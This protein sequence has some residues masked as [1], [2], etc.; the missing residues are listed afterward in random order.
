MEFYIIDDVDKPNEKF[1]VQQIND[2]GDCR[3]LHK[4]L[5]DYETLQL[6]NESINLE[7]FGF[8]ITIQNDKAIFTK[9]RRSTAKYANG[10]EKPW[11]GAEFFTLKILP[12]TLK[13]TKIKVEIELE[14]CCPEWAHWIATDPNGDVYFYRDKPEIVLEARWG[15]AGRRSLAYHTAAPNNR[16]KNWKDSLIKL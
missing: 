4:D 1:V 16:P 5:S 3:Y 2:D 14:L 8:K 11:Q 15:T 6:N 12:T 7:E 13:T 10:E 9:V